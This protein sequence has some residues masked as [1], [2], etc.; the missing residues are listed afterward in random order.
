MNK[1]ELIVSMAKQTGLTQSTCNKYLDTLLNIIKNALSEGDDLIIQNFGTL[2]V[3]QQTERI[4]RNPRTCEACMIQARN[5]VK[6]KA[7][8]ELIKKVN[9]LKAEKN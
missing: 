8:K 2:T 3:W 1:S 6:F 9:I 7:S 4:G 5:S